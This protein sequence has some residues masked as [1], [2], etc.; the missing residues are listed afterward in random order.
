MHIHPSTNQKAPAGEYPKN[1]KTLPEN[2]NKAE[3]KYCR[4]MQ[5]LRLAPHVG[6]WYVATSIR[7]IIRKAKYFYNECCCAAFADEVVN[8]EVASVEPYFSIPVIHPH[9]FLP[10]TCSSAQ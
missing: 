2:S 6:F 4:K 5:G 7:C 1:G 8:N 10:K 9:L 3:G